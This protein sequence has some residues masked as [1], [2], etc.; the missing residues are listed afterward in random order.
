MD[1]DD[2]LELR[3][4]GG[5]DLPEAEGGE[6]NPYVVVQCG[7]E[8]EQTH[9]CSGTTNPEWQMGGPPASHASS[10]RVGEGGSLGARREVI[11]LYRAMAT[12]PR[13]L[14]ARGQ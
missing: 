4:K 5:R 9:V 3:I 13:A 12:S 8:K 7:K 10:A 6:C 2:R 14:D 1:I 11:T